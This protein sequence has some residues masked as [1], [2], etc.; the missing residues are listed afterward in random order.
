MPK[1]LILAFSFLFILTACS[2]E[3]EV[4]RISGPTMGTQY[5]VSWVGDESSAEAIQADID[6]LLVQVNKSMS[7]Y[8]PQ[9]ELSLLNQQKQAIDQ[10]ISAGLADVLTEALEVNHKSEG[11]FDVTVGP[12]VNA[13]G[14]GPG[15]HLDERLPQNEVDDLLTQIGSDHIHLNGQ[16]L[17]S[18]IPL[19]IDLSAIAKGWGVDQVAELLVSKGINSYLV[20]IGGELRIAGNKPDGASWRIAIERPTSEVSDRQVQLILEPGQAGVATSGDYRNYFEENGVRYSHTINPKTGY[21]ITHRLASVTV[22]ADKCSMADAWATALNV[23]G[24]E[25]A[26]ELA[27]QNKLAAFI[28]VRTDT[29]FSEAASDEFKRRFPGALEQAAAGD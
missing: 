5:H 2:K 11:L 21:P 29:G 27:N 19:Y 28:I 23:A 12:L 13:W 18:D 9:S 8:D 25:L 6:A 3:P 20:E 14:F 26:M 4:V 16:Q 15:K 7:T 22:I 10:T 24:P 17:Q 1:H